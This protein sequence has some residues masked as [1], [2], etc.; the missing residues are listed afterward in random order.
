LT[1]TT[2]DYPYA[3][4]IDIA[5]P[6]ALIAQQTRDVVQVDK[7]LGDRV[8]KTFSFVQPDGGV[9]SSVLRM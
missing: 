2:M 7:E 6:T 3:C 4:E 5:F 9:K 8:T 1:M